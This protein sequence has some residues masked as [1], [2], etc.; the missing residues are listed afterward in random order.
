MDTAWLT[1]AR[2]QS[3]PIS[4]VVL[5]TKAEE[6][7]KEMDSNSVGHLE[8]ELMKEPALKHLCSELRQVN[9][10]EYKAIDPSTSS[11]CDVY[12]SMSACTHV[13]M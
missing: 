9:F 12:D 7:S 13:Y 2:A 1:A 11:F 4:E 10:I 6:L 3:V 8:I 5:K